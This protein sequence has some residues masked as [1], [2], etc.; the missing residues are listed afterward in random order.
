M[1]KT[2]CGKTFTVY[3]KNWPSSDG[4]WAPNGTTIT[5]D[6]QSITVSC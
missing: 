4:E 3:L 1:D 5:F 6:K 2:V